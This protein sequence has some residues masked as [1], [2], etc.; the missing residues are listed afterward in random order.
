MTIES[1]IRDHYAA[2][3]QLRAAVLHT[4]QEVAREYYTLLLP[5]APDRAKWQELLDTNNF[6][7]LN[8]LDMRGPRLSDQL[9]EEQSARAKLLLNLGLSL[10]YAAHDLTNEIPPSGARRH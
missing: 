1:R 2:I 6:S 3:V 8:S 5:V 10:E 9:P 4:K 7:A